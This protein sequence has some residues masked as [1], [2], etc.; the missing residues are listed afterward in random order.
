MIMH[1]EVLAAIR[2]SREAR[3]AYMREYRARKK[4]PPK[5][6]EPP[7]EPKIDPYWY[8]RASKM[9]IE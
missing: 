7:V 1:E 2:R 8:K 9:G 4:Q 3:A 5:P 6:P